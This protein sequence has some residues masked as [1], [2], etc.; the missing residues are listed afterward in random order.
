MGVSGAVLVAP[1][2]AIEERSDAFFWT[3]SASSV[4]V[5]P[6]D[7]IITE[8]VFFGSVNQYS[9]FELVVVMARRLPSVPFE[10]RS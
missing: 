3:C 5:P 4:K 10:L 7:L 9:P 8:P 6:D 2:D 1:P